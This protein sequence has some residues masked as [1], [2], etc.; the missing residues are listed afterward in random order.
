MRDTNS[1]SIRE[2]AHVIYGKGAGLPKLIS[3]L[4]TSLQQYIFISCKM[5]HQA[6]ITGLF[7]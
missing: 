4:T 1:L 7:T 6:D 3:A 5:L 2:C